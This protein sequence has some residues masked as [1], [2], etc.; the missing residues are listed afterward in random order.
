MPNIYVDTALT[1]HRK[2]RKLKRN[3]KEDDAT[4]L[5]YL[6]SLWCNI[7]ELAESGDITKWTV[8]D[9][10]EYSNYYGDPTTFYKF[11]INIGDGF[12]DEKPNGKRLIHD[13]LKYAGR[14]LTAKYGT[15]NPTKLNEI[16][17]LYSDTT[18]SKQLTDNYH[19]IDS[20]DSI[21]SIHI[22]KEQQKALLLEF[23]HLK[24]YKEDS[25]KDKSFWKRHCGSVSR[26]LE[27]AVGKTDLAIE[28]MRWLAKK[29]LKKDL[30]WTLETLWKKEWDE[31]L[32]SRQPKQ[33]P[34]V[35]TPPPSVNEE[36][37]K[38]VSDLVSETVK[39][40]KKKE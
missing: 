34:I 35:Y 10:A 7:L 1:R 3:L 2:F 27:T 6:V 33:P 28:G 23:I 29:Y 13:W 14:Y 26:V 36:E 40:M 9:I 17:R 30:T 39:E 16:K 20:I 11:L 38:K 4:V 37:K 12:I 24:G 19:S 21:D 31:F 32:K 18:V 5:G 15:R 8:E 22:T 25:L